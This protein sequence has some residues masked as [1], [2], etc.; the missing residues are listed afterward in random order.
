MKKHR[1]L[2]LAVVL[3]MPSLMTSGSLASEVLIF[4]LAAR[5]NLL[6]ETLRDCFHLGRGIFFKDQLHHCTYPDALAIANA[7]SAGTSHDGRAGGCNWQGGH[8]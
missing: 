8:P 7:G 6:L 3:I 4:G 2:A 1:F 5:C